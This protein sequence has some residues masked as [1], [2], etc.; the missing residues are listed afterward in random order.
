MHI[1]TKPITPESVLAEVS[2]L[3]EAKE[4]ARDMRQT[5]LTV[6]AKYGEGHPTTVIF[7]NRYWAFV[8]AMADH[9]A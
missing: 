4:I 3:A 7:S 1:S 8:D 2:S 9:F 5:A 6:A